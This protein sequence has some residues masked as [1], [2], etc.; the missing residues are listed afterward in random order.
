[1]GSV[2]RSEPAMQLQP[3]SE[4]PVKVVVSTQE[5]PVKQS[6]KGVNTLVMLVIWSVWRERNAWLFSGGS[7]TAYD[8]VQ[9]VREVSH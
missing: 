1:V 8:L 4:I 6:P 7:S 9:L 2:V 5:P 3:S